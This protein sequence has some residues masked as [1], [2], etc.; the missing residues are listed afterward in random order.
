MKPG[1]G[2]RHRKRIIVNALPV[3][4]GIALICS[5][6]SRIDAPVQPLPAVTHTVKWEEIK[7]GSYP[8]SSLRVYNRLFAP[9]ATTTIEFDLPGDAIV[10]LNVYDAGGVVTAK[11]LDRVQ[12]DAGTQE[13]EFDATSLAAGVYVY[14]LAARLLSSD[15]DLTSPVYVASRK[16]MLIK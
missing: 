7:D 12:M 6:C 11:L 1:S 8:S 13:V 14:T 4:V 10:S 3:V 9:N 15:L 16:M 5:G 2:T